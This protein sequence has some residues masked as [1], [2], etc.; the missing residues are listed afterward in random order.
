[1]YRQKHSKPAHFDFDLIIIGSGA[2][3]G[4]AAHTAAEAGKRV[5]I[6]EAGLLGGECPN[7]ACI[8][9]KALL[10]AAEVYETAKEAPRFGVRATSVVF[11]Y[12]SVKSWKDSVVEQTGV[13][14][15]QAAYRHEHITVLHGYAHFIDPWNISLAGRRFSARHFL[16]ATGASQSVPAIEGLRESGYITHREATNL[17][18]PPRSIFIIGGGAVGVEF[19]QL[20]NSFGSRVHIADAGPRLLAREDREV[21]VLLGV[22]FKRK[23]VQVH[24]SARIRSVHKS[25]ARK[26]VT[27][28][29]RGEIHTVHVEEVLVATGRMPNIDLGLDNAGVKYSSKGIKVDAT[30]RT[31]VAHIYAAGDVT[32]EPMFTHLASKASAVAVHNILHKK[33]AR[34]SHGPITRCVYASPEIAATGITEDELS[35]KRIPYQVAAAPLAIIARSGTSRQEAGFVKVL[36]SHT[37]VLLGASIVAPRAGEMIHELALAVSHG[38]KASH[39]SELTHAFPTWS[40]AVQVACSKINCL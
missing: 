5:A 6:V 4:V 2:G 29:I 35:A 24:T 15:S 3:G 21:G 7:Y 18:Q 10:R 31:N 9:T 36:A 39:V 32:G 19:A 34:A 20:F 16:I 27:F 30:Q 26:T 12:R 13:G 38:M 1:M 40:Q 11:N 37:G 28:E 14:D 8:P 33:K 23:G 25:G 22:L 17:T